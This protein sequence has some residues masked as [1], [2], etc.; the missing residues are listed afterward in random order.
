M[1]SFTQD[2]VERITQAAV[3]AA[4]AAAGKP[5]KPELLA[6]DRKNIKIWTKRVESAYIRA[7]ITTPKDKFAYV[8]GLID[9][10]INPRINEFLYGDATEETWHSFLE[11]L[12]DEY[13]RSR[14]QQ[15]AVFL[16]GIKRDGRRPSQLLAL[17]EDRAG[18]VTL[19]ELKELVLRELLPAVRRSMAERVKGLSAKEAALAANSYFDKEG[20]ALHNEPTPVHAVRKPRSSIDAPRARPCDVVEIEDVLDDD[21]T[22][23]NAAF[24]RPRRPFQRHQQQPQ[25][26][27]PDKA[28]APQRSGWN[29]SSR[30]TGSNSGGTSSTV[31][32]IDL[33]RRHAKFGDAAYECEKGCSKWEEFQAAKGRAARRT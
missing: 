29:N 10:N 14:E 23:V 12:H 16:D 11:Y 31:K 9:V 6:F 30:K 32:P 15:A 1:A 27:P 17:I 5:R 26:P 25:R 20:R 19:D 4:M 21:D 8:E 22:D 18:D 3:R 24:N 13:G 2:D 33:C 7:N 28:R